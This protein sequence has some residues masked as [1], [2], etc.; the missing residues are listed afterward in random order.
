[1]DCAFYHYGKCTILTETKCSENCKFKKTED[2]LITGDLITKKSL[3]D[4]G[5]E[6]VLIHTDEGPKISVRRKSD[7]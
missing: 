3:E 4:K 6:K 1:M 2:E 7:A 5:L